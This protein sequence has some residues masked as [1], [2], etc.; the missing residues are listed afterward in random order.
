MHK[1][2]I[3]GVTCFKLLVDD[4]PPW[5]GPR[6]LQRILDRAAQSDKEAQVGLVSNVTC[7]KSFR[8]YKVLSEKF[9]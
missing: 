1:F 7:L 8:N 4:K 2:S 3:K 9:F 6:L 5:L